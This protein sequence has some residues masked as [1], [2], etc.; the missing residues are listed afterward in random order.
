MA[1]SDSYLKSC[2]GR[3]REKVEEKADRDGLWVRVSK[4]GA[5]TFFYRYRFLGK[6]DKMTIGSYPAFSLKAAREEV[7]KWSAV[8]ARGENPR[9]RQGLDK[10]HIT[11]RRTFEELFREWHAMVCIQ[12]SSAYQV[13]RTFEL[14]VFPKLGK[15]PADQLT[16]HNWLT[17]LDRLAEGYTEITKRVISNGKQCYSWAVKRQLLEMNPLA[18][19]TGRDFGIQKKM[20]ERTLTRKEIAIVWRAME[21]SRLIERN[22]IL[23][24]LCLFWGCRVGELR[25]SEVQH[26][27][28]EEGVWTI[29]WENHKTGT[30]SKKPLI[31]P[32]IPEIVPLLSRAIALA[33]GKYVFSR[34]ADSAMSP[35]FHLSIS[36]NLVKF[37]LKAYKEQVPH[38][39]VHDLRRTARTNFSDLAD[40]HIAEIMLGHKLP[41]VWSVYDKHN[42]LD[43]MRNAYSKWWAR[44]MSIIEPDVIEF[45]PRQTG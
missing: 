26:F 37:M 21:D 35:S 25:L 11:S 12:K 15:Y 7:D 20:G 43:E 39:T 45:T 5:V 3:E 31:R 44:L 41:G 16:M 14:H 27:D 30:K 29:P 32:I 36:A 4:K 19:L 24:K 18:E 6:Q 38:F 23:F 2:L 10:A 8:L 40:P 1:I 28:F 22:K 34:Y 13:L 9:I 42:Y 17:V 33:P